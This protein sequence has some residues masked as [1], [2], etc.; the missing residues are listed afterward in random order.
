[1][2]KL[3]SGKKSRTQKSLETLLQAMEPGWTVADSAG[4]SPEA[5]ARSGRPLTIED[6]YE[7]KLTGDPNVSPDGA[8][9]AVAVQHIDREANEYRAAIWLFPTDGSAARQLTSGRWNDGSPRWSPDGQW[10]AFTSKR[11]TK[12]PQIW[13][14]PANGGEAHQ[15]GDIENG[16][17]SLS[18]APDSRRLAFTSTVNPEGYDPD[19]DV[20]VI[21]SARYKFDGKGFLDDKLTHIFTIDALADG[22]DPVQL[23]CG[24]FEHES[25]AWSPNGKEIAF[26]ANRDPGW[27]M[28]RVSDVWTVPATGGEPRRLTD[29]KGSWNSIAWSPDGAKLAIIGSEEVRPGV[30]NPRL[31]TLR[32]GSGK[33]T[34][35]SVNVD[36][37]L[38]DRSMSGPNGPVAGQPARWTPDGK[39]VDALVSDRG[40]TLV[41]RFDTKSGKATVLTG[42][43]RHINAF[44]HLNDGKDLV[45]AVSD[46]TTPAK[47]RIVTRAGES[48]L[49]S[50]NDAWLAGVGIATPEEFWVESDG[51]AVQGWLLRPTGNG[52][53]GPKV[54]LV[55]NVHGG[56]H[57]QF[58]PAFFH[59]IQLYAARGYALVY[60]N[61]RGSLGYDEP[62]AQKVTAAWGVA[63]SPDFLAAI[64]HVV[65]LGGIDDTR[66]GI[67]GGSYGGFITNWML[68]TTDRFKVGVTDRSISNMISMYGT[69][70]IALVSLDPDLGTPWENLE[71]YW[72]QSPLKHVANITAPLLIVHSE[73]DYRCP[74]EQAEQLFIALKRLGR[75][76]E[77]VRFPNESHGL[78]RNG[79]PKH[80]VERL[81]RTL[82]WFEKYL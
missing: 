38:G 74:M 44:D 37:A 43:D 14:L 18:W 16:A 58:S 6:I 27:E 63:D 25:P 48:R 71:R 4:R 55:L 51:H 52:P 61:P 34:C 39:A 13:L 5:P 53:R 60:I 65:D 73:N 69:D 10:L 42:R 70:D 33:L 21:T 3:L 82:G 12:T 11:A 29:G 77:F 68:G 49:S 1:M 56:P 64:D 57:A 47:L 45:I 24:D 62:F 41:V 32:A 28:S 22:A 30:Q 59:E 7:L 50:F 20:R 26:L 66:I 31:F 17:S 79:G 9:I 80:R 36:R 2:P 15:V 54:P 46:P 67:T 78:S 75:T 72:D 8:S 76:V 35:L 81:E 19:H 40:S 23:T